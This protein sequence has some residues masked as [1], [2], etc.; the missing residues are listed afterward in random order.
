MTSASSG[1]SPI[2]PAEVFPVD[3]VVPGWTLDV[4]G[5]RVRSIPPLQGQ[6]R[7]APIAQADFEDRLGGRRMPRSE[8]S[9]PGPPLPSPAR[10]V[11][12]R[13]R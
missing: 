7:R 1:W 4:I 8:S 3:P 13:R 2:V 12:S 11:A 10:A 6:V 9:E 5:P